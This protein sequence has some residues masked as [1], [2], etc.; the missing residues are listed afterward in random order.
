MS[1]LRRLFS[2]FNVLALLVLLAAAYTY[3]LVQRPVA[4]PALPKLQ[5]TEVHPV[6][7][8]VYYTD[9]QVQTLKPL[10]RTVNVA[11]ETPTALAQAATDAWA[12]GPGGLG[13]DILPVLPAGTPAP[14]IYVRGV[15]Y[16]ADLPAAYGKLNYGTS[17]ER[18]LLCSLTRTLLDKRGDDVTFLLDGKNIDTLGHLDL[19]DAFTRQDCMDQ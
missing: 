11:E 18:V 4:L 6:K 16:Y 13:D 19:R 14:R 8:K 3:Q 1:A 9:K 2:L 15:H 17:G 10:E 7:L 12:R 5:L